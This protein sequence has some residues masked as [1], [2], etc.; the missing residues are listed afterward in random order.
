MGNDKNKDAAPAASD[1]E[2]AIMAN[3]K[4]TRTAPAPLNREEA[5]KKQREIDNEARERSAAIERQAL[6][7]AFEMQQ[8]QAEQEKLR[9]LPPIM[10]AVHAEVARP[11]EEC[12]LMHFPKAMFI[13]ANP[14]ADAPEG[15]VRKRRLKV[16]F[17]SGVQKVPVS[18]RDDW[19]LKAAGAVEV[20]KPGDP[21]LV[22]GRPP[23]RADPSKGPT[24]QEHVIAGYDAHSYPP[25]GFDSKSTD[26]EIRAAQDAQ[27]ADPENR[28]TKRRAA[29]AGDNAA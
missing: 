9:V 24:V 26:E 3:Q 12:V 19:Y 18:L 25:V 8:R 29:E 5:A 28:H 17:G 6:S 23:L 10:Q 13:W 7:F 22:E 2:K 11:D 21:G 15:D 4:S 27:D 20:G 1:E 16:A 14:V